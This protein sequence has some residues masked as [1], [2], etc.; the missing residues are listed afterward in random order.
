MTEDM[1]FGEIREISFNNLNYAVAIKSSHK[2]DTLEKMKKLALEILK[3][4][5]VEK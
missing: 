1:E 5:Q 4:I 2:G 3:D